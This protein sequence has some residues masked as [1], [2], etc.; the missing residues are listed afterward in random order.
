LHLLTSEVFVLLGRA[1]LTLAAALC[2]GACG[3][4]APPAPAQSSPTYDAGGLARTRVKPQADR[5]NVIVLT[6]DTLR[7]DAIGPHGEAGGDMPNLSRLA[8]EGVWFSEASSSASWTLPA[9]A[10]M[11]TGH[12]PHRHGITGDD[13]GGTGLERLTT[14]AEVMRSTLG[15]QTAAYFGGLP[16][17]VVKALG[18]GFEHVT[19]GFELQQASPQLERWI[20]ARR[21]DRPFFLFLHSFEAHDPYGE[22]NHPP[23][24]TQASARA[25]AALEALGPNPRAAD[26]LRASVLDGEQ[27]FLLR[28]HPRLRTFQPAI[29]RYLW[30]GL[31][32]DPEPGLPEELEA[33]YRR[34]LRWVDGLVKSTLDLLRARGLL[35]NTLLIVTADHGEAFGE[36]GMLLHGRQ[37]YD[38]LVRV[39]LILR[40]PPPFDRPLEVSSSVG[41]TDLFPTILAWLG[42]PAP[43]EI[44]G[45][46]FLDTFAAPGPGRP[47]LAEES[48]SHAHTGG[49]SVGKVVSV[50]HAAWKYIGT[51]DE[52]AGTLRE[53]AY[54]LRSDPFETRNLAGADGFVSDL[55]F[56]PAFCAALE[57]AR[58]RLWGSADQAAWTVQQGYSAGAYSTAVA[59]PA[60]SCSPTR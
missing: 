27:R 17:A 31:A 46:S 47:V 50:R 23:G 59:R 45:R 49:L 19:D 21:S 20:E 56:D 3:T 42:A 34:G 40:G 16:P 58:D 28:T 43:D 39:P 8:R 26:L 15:Y 25:L 29:T 1:L 6:I 37:L 18:E 53:E 14:W 11:F 5:P 24:G 33:A 13:I 4:Q 41:L 60:S 9:L 10:S 51:L 7:A 30:S 44:E 48:R 54:D 32:T 35:E 2:C 57:R 38:E 52:T 55:P 22:A 36:H 12:A